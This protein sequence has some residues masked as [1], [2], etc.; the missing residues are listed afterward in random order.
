MPS[1]K[2]TTAGASLRRFIVKGIILV[3]ATACVGLAVSL[4]L[5]GAWD[6]VLLGIAVGIGI[7]FG[8]VPFCWELS[9]EI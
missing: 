6:L 9:N 4:I 8:V 2:R 7:P 5:T 3:L 1:D